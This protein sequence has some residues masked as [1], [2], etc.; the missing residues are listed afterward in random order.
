MALK[1]WFSTK[2]LGMLILMLIIA[3]IIAAVL[4]RTLRRMAIARHE[5]KR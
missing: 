5:G 2:P 1:H 4:Y 3:L